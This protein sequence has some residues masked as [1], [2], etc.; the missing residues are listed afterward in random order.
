MSR[1]T[2]LRPGLRIAGLAGLLVVAG[3]RNPFNPSSD[4]ELAQLRSN[5]NGV[6]DDITIQS[7]DL[8]VP[9]PFYARWAAIAGFVIKNKVAATLTSVNIVYTDY[10]GNEVTAYTTTGGKTFKLVRRL[11]P[12][13][14]RNAVSSYNPNYGEGSGTDLT[15]YPIDPLVKATFTPSYTPKFMLATITFR[16]EDDNGYDWKLVGSIGIKVY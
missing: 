14:D 8:N 7:A 9:N 4:I 3:C 13:D 1:L 12:M 2:D 15:I 5:G 6:G 10:Y 16:G 11:T